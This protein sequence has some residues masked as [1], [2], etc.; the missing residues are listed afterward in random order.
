MPEELRK[1][2]DD[3]AATARA[4]AAN[5]AASEVLLRASV[6]SMLDPQ[7][8]LEAVRGA[9]GRIVDFRYRSVNAVACAFFGIDE[10]DLVGR[11]QVEAFPKLKGSELHHRYIRCVEN[12]EPVV[13]YDFRYFSTICGD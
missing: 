8:L 7:V 10:S 2:A 4:L 3:L 5:E 12:G 6:D 13:L 9:D 1:L 11:T